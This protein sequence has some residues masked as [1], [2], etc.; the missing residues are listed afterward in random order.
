MSQLTY[1]ILQ[2]FAGILTIIIL[3]GLYHIATK[4]FKI[5]KYKA[6]LSIL[7]SYFIIGLLTYNVQKKRIGAVCCDDSKSLATGSGACS[8]HGGVREWEISYKYNEYKEPFNTLHKVLY[9]WYA[10][11]ENHKVLDHVSNCDD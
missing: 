9:F 6:A 3:F 4:S 5:K 1:T 11:N 2:F 8:F 7:I 10:L